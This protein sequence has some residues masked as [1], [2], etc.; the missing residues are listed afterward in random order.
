MPF[1]LSIIR[2]TYKRVSGESRLLL[3]AFIGSLITATVVAG[4]PVYLRTLE[5]AGIADT[6]DGVGRYYAN[7]QVTSSWVPLEPGEAAKAH[8][9][10]RDAEAAH[11]P[12]A[13]LGYA[14][15]IR[16]RR[17]F[18]GR[19]GEEMPR[20]NFDSRAQFQSFTGAEDHIV[21]LLGRH[22]T[23]RVEEVDGVLIVEAG[24]LSR[25]AAHH[26]IRIGDVI[27]TVP[28]VRGIGLV[29]VRIT[30]IFTV[31]DPEEEF[32]LAQSVPIFSPVPI[33]E[34]RA[35]P[36]VLLV[37]PSTMLG[38]IAESN[39]GLPASYT[40]FLFVDRDHFKQLTLD[41]SLERITSFENRV[42]IDVIRSDVLTSLEPRFRV[43][44]TRML[45]ARIP[46]LLLAALAL[47]SIGYYLFMVAGIIARR[48]SS[49]TGMMRSRGISIQ[50][51]VRTYATESVIIAGIPAI[52]GPLLAL[53][54]VSVL[55][56]LPFYDSV[57]TGTFLPVEVTWRS[58]LWSIIAGISI[59]FILLIPAIMTARRGIIDQH[60][61]EARPDQP[62]L[63]QRYYLD[64]LFLGL[65]ALIWWELSSRGSIVQSNREGVA[66]T[67]VTL[68]FSPAVFLLV[69]ALLFLR[70]FPWIAQVV[71]V[72][73]TRV[74]AADVSLGLWRLRRSP[75][76]YAWPVL[77]LVLVTGLGV[78]SGT[79]ASTLA[80]ST[81]EQILYS[82][83]S[84]FRLVPRDSIT[85]EQL[86]QV[87]QI[88][89][90]TSASPAFRSSGRFGT[91][92]LGLNFDLLAVDAED[93]AQTAWFRDDFSETLIEQL[94]SNIAVEVKPEPIVLP[95][96]TVSLGAWAKT[97]PR[98]ENHFLWL[99]IK[100]GKGRARTVT[101]GQI[102]GDWR[103]QSTIMS[104]AL[105]EPAQLVSVQTF[106]QA[107]PDGSSPTTLFVDDVYAETAD[108]E[109][110]LLVDFDEPGSWVGMPT[111]NGLD[112]IYGLGDESADL[113]VGAESDQGAS[114]AMV[115]LDRGNDQGVRGIY[116][117]ATGR[118]LPVVASKAFLNSTNTTVGSQ[119]I[120]QISGGFM[121]VEIVDQV[122]FFP[123]LDPRRS[124]F[125]VA[126]INSTIDFLELRGLTVHRANQLFVRIEE[127]THDETL[128]GLRDVFRFASLTDRERLLEDS[129][130]DPLVV[131]GWRGMSIVSIVMAGIAAAFGYFTYLA[132]HDDR[133]RR[134]SAFLQSMGMPAY[135]FARLMLV[136]HAI[137]AVLGIGIGIASGLYVSWLAVNSL[138]FTDTGRELLPPF[139]MQTNWTPTVVLTAVVVISTGIAIYNIMKRYR[140]MPL[141]EL[142]RGAS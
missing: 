32:W 36:I 4:G 5:G 138:T 41:E 67:D 29:K 6:V 43:L 90:V 139:I 27:D 114:V 39:A 80:R 77:L 16:S 53:G 24:I 107:G 60:Q 14:D 54:L 93:F 20:G 113:V 49:E 118:P 106:S 85:T 17:A 99:V 33:V 112:I 97:E 12:D 133:T 38:P 125:L 82:S 101:L 142:T 57:A 132:A 123:T 10:V 89:G 74:A 119:I 42:D 51:I 136:E 117:T 15:L 9:A 37:Q 31:V 100:D 46:M 102:E 127:G 129:S 94:T 34:G 26:D 88:P 121:P 135:S 61:S 109:R 91:T 130:V 75:Y 58:W 64:L 86:D 122:A 45:Y 78:V 56:L 21:Y 22:P 23:N 59:F 50:Q 55:G 66:S 81:E 19:Q 105:A 68:L 30:G 18:W 76:W 40:W 83:G 25:R 2:L 72:I 47:A 134:D 140:T 73:G 84:D 52:V 92:S 103:L 28:E 137:V 104:S 96:N 44:K 115:E 131:A 116:R 128:G 8:K 95:P 13:T 108:G 65:G 79:L 48:R 98:V 110:V 11:L 126:N 63:F 111:S 7:I 71:A 1:D 35:L 120:V 141:H 87:K 70:L 69:V 3:G 62:P 124:P